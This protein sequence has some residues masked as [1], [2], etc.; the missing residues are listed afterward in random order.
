[1]GGVGGTK[2]EAATAAAAPAA[3]TAAAKGEA[4][5]PG[6]RTEL[7]TEMQEGLSPIYPAA[8][9]V[10]S[11]SEVLRSGIINNSWGGW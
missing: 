10:S 9:Q 11:R 6:P 3:T 4:L 5:H 2:D 8:S 7:A 1:M